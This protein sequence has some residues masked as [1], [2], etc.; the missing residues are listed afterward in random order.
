[1]TS[2]VIRLVSL[3]LILTTA[4]VSAE[5][6]CTVLC[7]SVGQ[8]GVLP[9]ESAAQHDCHAPAANS[10]ATAILGGT[11]SCS[12]DHQSGVLGIV[13]NR[14]DVRAS[15]TLIDTSVG[16]EAPS[17]SLLPAPSSLPHHHGPPPGTSVPLRI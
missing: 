10:T 1:M 6:L 16:W 7:V 14:I 8:G 2:S 5:T 13:S 15:T 11:D 9:G 12:T 4:V 17:S 3:C